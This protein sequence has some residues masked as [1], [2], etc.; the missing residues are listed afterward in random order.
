MTPLA[1]VTFC[2]RGEGSKLAEKSVINHVLEYDA[3]DVIDDII[4]V[5]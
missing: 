5:T 2:D 4:G 3:F 1:G